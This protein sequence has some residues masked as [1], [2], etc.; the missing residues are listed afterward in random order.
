GWSLDELKGRRIP[1]VPEEEQA[2]TAEQLRILIGK[3]KKVKFETV[4]LTKSGK[5]LPVIVSAACIK[6]KKGEIQNIVVNLTDISRQ[7]KMQAAIKEQSDNFNSVYY[8][9]FFAI[10]TLD[11]K[12]IIDCNSALVDMMGADSRKALLNRHP[13]DFSP[14]VQ[15]DGQNSY[16]KADRM[17]SIALEK[18]FN[19]FEWTHTKLTG[20]EVIVDVSLTRINLDGNP[21]LHCIWKDLTQEKTLIRNLNRAKEAAEAAAKAKSEFLANMSHEIRTPMNGV[22]GMID[23]L[24]ETKMTPEQREFALSVSTSA[25]SLLMIINDIL[26]FSKIEAGKLDMEHIEFDLRPV[27]E[28][29]G[30]VMAIKAYEK[31]IEFACLIHHRVPCLLKGDPGRLR[32]ILT[33]LAGNAV[34]FVE[35]GEVE[36]SVDLEAETATHA[37]LV[38][39]V[40]DTGIGIEPHRLDK[41]F[42]SFTQADASMTRRYGGTGLGLTI[43]K[44]LTEMMGG[45]ISVESRLGEGST[46]TFSVHLEKQTQARAPIEPIPD[47][48]KGCRVLVVD[49]H[50]MNREVF[51]E[52][53]KSW[54]C[55]FAEAPDADAG[56]DAMKKAV[57]DGDPFDIAILDMQMPGITGETLGKSIRANPAYD[58]TALVMAT[59]MGQRGDADRMQAVGFSAFVTKPVKKNV[60]FDCLRMVVGKSSSPA[61]EAAS[62][63]ITRHSVEEAM[64]RKTYTPMALN[65]LLAED[66]RMN[67]KVATNMLKKMGHRVSVAN[68]GKEAVSLFEQEQFHLI[69]MDGQMPVMAGEEAARQIRRIE[70]QTRRRHTPIIA[71]TANAMKGDRERF[72][73]AGMDDYLPKPIKRKVLEAVITKVVSLG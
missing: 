35:T 10:S 25:D 22:I 59:S 57:K 60:L 72:L 7:K 66:N 27:V 28:S 36:V 45:T 54:E 24:L 40:R 13:G 32:Q 20:G 9:A 48:I 6:G 21:V 38:F 14:E 3:G 61:A 23:M 62:R 46:F 50:K 4:R 8:G 56:L 43:S 16:E 55:R 5:A 11:R 33:N 12:G 65:I 58:R 41:L 30:D 49:D 53:L 19:N 70:A 34:K 17:I 29:L 44:Q 18:G 47:N 51:R 26:D 2:A 68:N 39:K 67:Q 31:G 73:A 63:I 71:V 37:T 52:Y 69:L 1:F 64:E 15:P 42:D